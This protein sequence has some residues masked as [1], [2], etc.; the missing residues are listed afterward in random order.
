[1][2]RVDAIGVSSAGIYIN[3]QTK[4]AS[5]FRKVPADQ[6]EAII[7]NIYINAAKEIGDIPVEV[8]NDGDVTALA[9]S[10][11]LNDNNI[12][13]IAM[14]T[15]QAG[16]YVDGKGY[17]TGWLNE[18]AF[19][20]IDATPNG[21]LD[22][23]SGDIGCGVMYFSQDGVIRLA[24]LAG[25]ELD[26]NATPAEKLAFVQEEV[27]KGNENA[28]KIFE[29]IG[30]CLGHAVAQY[31]TVYDI[32][33]VLLMGRVVSGKGGQLILDNT[34]KVLAEEYPAVAAKTEV[35]LPDEK[36]RRVGQSVAAAS[37]PSI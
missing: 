4:I 25:V 10:M 26:E 3:N 11:S 27:K 17:L 36:S 19:T 33:H 24:P 16:G 29:A 8:A 28:D 37:L 6:H 7:K 14:G 12:L 15:S 34:N 13:G 23:W 22:E 30:V 18:L 31:S 2:P 5:L 32:K 21:P 9:G 20:P 1:M 35:T